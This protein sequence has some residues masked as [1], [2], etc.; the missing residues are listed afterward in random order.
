MTSLLTE[1]KRVLCC[2]CPCSTMTVS[3]MED[4]IDISLVPPAF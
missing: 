3:Y 1:F 4:I 2:I